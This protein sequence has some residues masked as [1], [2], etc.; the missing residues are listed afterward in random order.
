MSDVDDVISYDFAAIEA[1]VGG[2]IRLTSGRLN[3]ALADLRA[4]IAPLRSTWTAETATAFGIEADRWDRAAAALNDILD[5]L[6][7]AVAEGAQTVADAD[8]AEARRWQ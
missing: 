6:A 2:Q 7:G 3:T 8:R 4:R 5:R 1:Q